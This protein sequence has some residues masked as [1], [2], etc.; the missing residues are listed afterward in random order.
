MG[1]KKGRFVSKSGDTYEVRLS[2][3]S[4]IGGYILFG[5]PPVT[6]SMA[7]GEH[8]FCGFK[9]TTAVVN[10]RTDVPL[11]DL[12]AQSV[13]DVQLTVENITKGSIEFD[14]YVTPFAFDQP[15]TGKRDSV[16]VNAVDL[17]SVRKDAKY[18]NIGTE[19]GTDRSAL[20]IVQEICKRAGVNTIYLHLNFNDTNDMM[21][22]ASP[23][24]VMV[25]Q[26]GFLQD[27]VS[28]A[29]ALSAICKF[30]GYTGHVIGR[31]LYLYDEYLLDNNSDVNVYALYDSG[32]TRVSHSF[33][34]KN[35]AYKPQS[36]FAIHNDI[37]VSVERAYDGIQ[38][39]PEG[40]DTSIL[41]PDVLDD[42]NIEDITDAE[43]IPVS[44]DKGVEYRQRKRSLLLDYGRAN[45]AGAPS[46]VDDTYLADNTWIDAAVLYQRRDS[47]GVEILTNVIAWIDKSPS[48]VLW[49]R[50]KPKAGDAMLRLVGKQKDSTGFSHTR[51]YVKVNIDFVWSEDG[52][53]KGDV[54]PLS[55]PVAR[56]FRFLRILCG[57][58]VFNIDPSPY[59]DADRWVKEPIGSI[60]HYLDNKLVP[61]G[62]AQLFRKDAIIVEIPSDGQVKLDIGWSESESSYYYAS[63]LFVTKLSLEGWGEKI[64]TECSHM[65]H[66]FLGRTDEMLEVSLSLTSRSATP[67]RTGGDYG[68]PNARPGVVTSPDFVAP[69]NASGSKEIPISG[70][71]MTQLV[72]RYGQPR[73][74]YKMTVDGNIKPYASVIFNDKSYT[75]EAYDRDIYNDTTTITID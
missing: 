15:F 46:S 59:Y 68:M 69:Y 64:D 72:G 50:K 66:S 1:I 33:N 62:T 52:D 65:K 51:G 71:L 14:G 3:N 44:I 61:N 16:T 48:N 22:N 7:A 21:K 47:E 29:D 31:S 23:L 11:I 53:W 42:E 57:D 2:G 27:E 34:D 30:F 49:V 39:K 35:S 10:I 40:S 45:V 73:A 25:A 75:V 26:A 37:S 32:W 74:A 54:T 12:Y 43:E 38:I 28:D 8:K 9:G 18:E 36:I 24:D 13:T 20:S 56:N 67:G 63:N 55:F 5:V 4:V 60:F 19:H 6:I 17:I 70:V 41:L 58:S